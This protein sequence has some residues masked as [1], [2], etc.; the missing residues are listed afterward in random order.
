LD[1][2]IG[3]MSGYKLL[4]KAR[5]LDWEI[6]PTICWLKNIENLGQRAA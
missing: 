1:S 5:V 4:G 6:S 3:P 2:R